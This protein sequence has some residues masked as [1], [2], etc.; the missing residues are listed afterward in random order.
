[1]IELVTA[2]DRLQMAATGTDPD[3]RPVE[4]DIM[5]MIRSNERRSEE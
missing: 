1:M 2:P 5:R 3:V 4:I